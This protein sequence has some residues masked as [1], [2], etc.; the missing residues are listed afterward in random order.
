VLQRLGLIN[1][2]LEEL[3]WCTRKN[4]GACGG[5]GINGRKVCTGRRQWRTAGLGGGCA[6]VRGAAGAGFYRRW[7]SVRGSWGQPRR[8]CTRGVGSKARRRAAER[9]PNGERR[10]ARRRVGNS[11]LAPSK[12]SRTSR[13]VALRRD[14]WTDGSSG[15]STCAR[16]A[17]GG[18]TWR[19]RHRARAR[20]GV[21]GWKTVR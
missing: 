10:L 5:E 7:R 8:R 19:A 12:C 15:A 17:Y 16:R 1:K 21:A 6:C 11:H 18:Q 13:T 2:R 3:L 9:R 20:S 4:S 14:A